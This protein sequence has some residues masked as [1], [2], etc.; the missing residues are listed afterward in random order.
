MSTADIAS[1]VLG[2]RVH[3]SVYT[4]PAVFA[5]EQE[6]LF[7]RTWLY[8]G[9]LSQLPE[10]G[11][12]F[13]TR[14]AGTPVVAV[15]QKDGGVAV[16]VNRCTHRGAEL[17]QADSGKIARL[18]CPYHGWTFGLD[19]Q[20]IG[21]PL[22]SSYPADFDMAAKAL[23]RVPRVDTYRGFI[24][25]CFDADVPPLAEYMGEI[26]SAIDDM[27]DR[28]PDGEVV[29][30]GGVHRHGFRGNWKLQMENLNDYAHPAFAHESSNQA[31][32][33]QD[34][35][36]EEVEQEDIMAANRDS[37]ADYIEQA[38]VWAYPGGHSFIG[39][40]A[41][42]NDVNPASRKAYRDAM[43]ARHGE[44]RTA[45]IL[46]I[47]RHVQIVYPTLAVQGVFQQIKVIQPISVDYTEVYVYCFHLKGAPREYHRAAAT[48]VN[49]AN[50]PASLILTD[51]LTIYER[52][53]AAMR[54]APRWFSFDS[55]KD[56][57][58]ADNRGGLHGPGTSELAMRNQFAVWKA[59]LTDSKAPWRA[60]TA[61]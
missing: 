12:Y 60:R 35:R 44:A 13:R 25:A 37:D 59:Y 33:P 17:C 42:S 8:V 7:R 45:E 48:F 23:D 3:S 58:A 46:G 18:R 22:K 40:L 41:I 61:A 26:R 5:L 15:R 30:G 10:T 21:V 11:A 49:A 16:L 47:N 36:Q 43:I 57:S 51:D 56:R 31:A 4:D 19:G 14:L 55:G 29:L 27:V 39:G 1:L 54:D 34:R 6:R 52:A 28:A 32:R 9:H 53:Q 2:E 50:S 20:L 24:F 38:G